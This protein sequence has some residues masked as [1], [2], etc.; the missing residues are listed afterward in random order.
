MKC[1]R[2]WKGSFSRIKHTR[3][4]SYYIYRHFA[5]STALQFVSPVLLNVKHESRNVYN[6]C[7]PWKNSKVYNSYPL[8][9]TTPF[10][11][12]LKPKSLLLYHQV[13]HSQILR[14]PSRMYL[15]VLYRFRKNSDYFFI[16]HYLTCFITEAV[17]LPRGTK[18]VFF[19][20]YTLPSIFDGLI[21]LESAAELAP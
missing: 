4:S 13:K 21:M 2:I 12:P 15:C 18:W 17:C 19:F 10:M 3:E 20:K 5:L 8:L 1:R 16:Q 9:M 14:S 6:H 11:S 7:K